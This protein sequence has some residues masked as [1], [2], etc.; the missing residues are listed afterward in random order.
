ML[1]PLSNKLPQPD[2]SNLISSIPSPHPRVQTSLCTVAELPHCL[3][4]SD[5]CRCTPSENLPHSTPSRDVHIQ[6]AAT[7]SEIY[8]NVGYRFPDLDDA[9]STVTLNRSE[10]LAFTGSGAEPALLDAHSVGEQLLMECA[11]QRFFRRLHQT[12][13]RSQ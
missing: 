10:C 9:G 3:C 12:F 6:S 11:K 13:A 4:S 5:G 2:K 1:Q 8:R 7:M